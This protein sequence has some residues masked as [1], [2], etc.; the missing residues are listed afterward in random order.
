MNLSPLRMKLVLIAV[1]LWPSALR[2][3]LR[4]DAPT[5]DLGEMRAGQRLA[6]TFHFANAGS[7][8]IDG[9]HA[10][11][12][13]GCLAA[14]LSTARLEPGQRASVVVE[15]NTLGQAAGPHTWRATLHYHEEGVPRQQVVEMRGVLTTEVNVQPAA[16]TL[17]T[18]GVLR[19]E[20]TLTDTRPSPLRITSVQTTVAGIKAQATSREQ[21]AQGHTICKIAVEASAELPPGRHE[22]TLSIFTDDPAYR[23]LQ[24]PIRVIKQPRSALSVGPRELSFPKTA[25]G[26]FP[27]RLLRVWS[28]ADAPVDVVRVYADHPALTCTWAAGPGKQATIK[29]VVDRR[30]LP[31]A[32]TL[33]SAIHIEVRAPAT[34]TVTIPIAVGEE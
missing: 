1:A 20:I 29:V 31:E 16:L 7:S 32:Q 5:I 17:F 9:L 4:F 8:V 33:P 2:A 21:N 27:A 3:E 11:P 34:E 30:R 26:H 14:R 22:D 28:A 13:C 23:Q 10:R 18:E 19:Q 25:E 6:Q 24:M 15:V 12:E